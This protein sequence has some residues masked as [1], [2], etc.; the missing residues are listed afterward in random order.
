MR[1]RRSQQHAW[2]QPQRW[3]RCAAVS[4]D[5]TNRFDRFVLATGVVVG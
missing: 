5:V 2:L 3:V 1:A 4:L